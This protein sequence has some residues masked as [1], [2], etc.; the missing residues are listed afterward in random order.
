MTLSLSIILKAHKTTLT[1]EFTGD[2]E[3][4][5]FEL[6]PSSASLIVYPGEE[7]QIACMISNIGNISMEWLKN[8]VPVSS[9]SRLEITQSSN[10]NIRSI[11]SYGFQQFLTQPT[12]KLSV[13]GVY[14]QQLRSEWRVISFPYSSLSANW[15]QNLHC[16]QQW[17][18]LWHFGK[19]RVSVV[20]ILSLPL[21]TAP[22]IFFSFL[23][24]VRL[25]I[26]SKVFA[27]FHSNKYKETSGFLFC[28]IIFT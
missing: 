12:Y 23:V 10:E 3:P 4:S 7:Q 18:K 8:N 9:T 15:L 28:C 14:Q 6:E 27:I 13:V 21:C 2:F 20:F 5:V 1:K 17:N 25:Y 11:I 16:W 26:T 24:S 22:Q 19:Q